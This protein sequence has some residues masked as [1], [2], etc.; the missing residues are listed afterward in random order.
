MLV[1]V[2]RLDGFN[3]LKFLSFYALTSSLL[4]G[5]WIGHIYVTSTEEERKTYQKSHIG[6]GL[7][8]VVIMS[9][10]FGMNQKIAILFFDTDG[11]ASELQQTQATML[12]SNAG[13]LNRFSGSALSTV[14]FLKEDKRYTMMCAELVG[15]FHLG[16]SRQLTNKS[17]LP[18]DLVS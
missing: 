10:S 15:D 4:F 12:G 1:L 17:L 14:M 16:D 9:M 13:Q 11:Y 18:F 8:L 3:D 7:F 6:I 5:W 2:F